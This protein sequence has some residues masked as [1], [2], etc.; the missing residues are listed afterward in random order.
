[1]QVADDGALT[2]LRLVT[3]FDCG[4]V[5]DPANLVNQVEGAT[6]MGLGGA[7]FEQVEFTGGRML[8]ASMTRYRVPRL[9]DVPPVEVIL[10]NRP[11]LPPVGG[12]E[13]PL[14][15]VA[16]AIAN[17]IRHATGVRLHDLPL[18][19]SGIVGR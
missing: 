18:A 11:D 7:L 15:A 3:A 2:V 10:V 5:A 12:G 1:V 14:I 19:P 16:P 8:N 4:A 9:P 17:A 6:V 13:T